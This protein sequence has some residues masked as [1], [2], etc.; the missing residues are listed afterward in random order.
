MVKKFVDSSDKA[1]LLT[2]PRRWGKSINLS[3]IRSFLEIELDKHGQK[4]PRREK[5]VKPI[6]ESGK[7]NTT[8]EVEIDNIY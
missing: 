1:I 2:F 8:G 6:F 7:I 5:I 4:L 3:M